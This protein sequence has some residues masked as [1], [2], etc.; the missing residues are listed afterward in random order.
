M[1]LAGHIGF[2]FNSHEACMLGG[3]INQRWAPALIDKLSLS[4]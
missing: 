3:L 4:G 1:A 2:N